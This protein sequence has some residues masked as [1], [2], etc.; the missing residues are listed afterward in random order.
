VALEIGRRFVARGSL[1]RLEDVFD[2]EPG[3]IRGALRGEPGEARAIVARRR[4]ERAW[5]LAHPAPAEIGE[6]PP[7]AYRT[8]ALPE[9]LR[10][11]HE[12]IEWRWTTLE[13][14]VPDPP[15]PS[16]MIAGVPGSPGRHTG[17]VRLVRGEEDLGRVEPGDVVVCQTTVPAWAPLFGTAGALITDVG[18]VLSHPAILARE[19]GIPAVL[20]TGLATH[21]LPE[22]AFVT[23][24]GTAGMV[25]IEVE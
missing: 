23:V 24:D 25:T 9:P 20:A 8:D 7:P 2:L 18:D 4:A 12:A 19:H 21:R 10:R 14:R 6:L 16:R 15:D 22:G 13:P 17:R 5:V 11:I 3:E 1:G